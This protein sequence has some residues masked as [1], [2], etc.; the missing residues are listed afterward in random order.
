MKCIRENVSCLPGW[1]LDFVLR[2]PLL[3]LV[4]AMLATAGLLRFT[5]ANFQVNT[6]LSEMISPD[7][8][9]RKAERA[10]QKAFP[11]LRDQ[12]AL[13]VEAPTPEI[14]RYGQ[15]VLA[16]RLAATKGL[17]RSIYTPGGGDF[18]ARNGLLYLPVADLQGL[19]DNL[20]EMQ[21][22]LGMLPAKLTPESF[23]SMLG[24]LIDKGG[25]QVLANR[26][27]LSLFSTLASAMD[28][29]AAGRLQEVSWEGV[30]LGQKTGRGPAREFITLQ[31]VLD[32]TSLYPAHKAIDAIQQL[33]AG[34]ESE[35]GLAGVRVRLTGDL[36]LQQA[37]MESVENGTVLAAV[38][39]M[40][41]VTLLL[42]MG[43][44]SGLLTAASLLT[45]ALGLIWTMGFAIGAIGSL[46]LISVTFVVLFIG[47]GVDFSIQICLRYRE[48]L[49]EGKERTEAVRQAAAE[50]FNPQLVSAITIAI[51]FYA[52]V[53][54]AYAGASELGIISGTGIVLFLLANHAVL[55]AL[56]CLLPVRKPAATRGHGIPFDNL[57]RR[58]GRKILLVAGLLA[59]ASLF[60][61][62]RVRFDYN[63]LDLS[64]P[65]AEAVEVAKEL[66]T[67]GQTSPWT[68]SIIRKGLG[69][70]EET[71]SRLSR[72]PEVDMA[73]TIASYVPEQQKEK[74]AIIQDTA[75]FMPPLPGPPDLRS[76]E[77]EPGYRGLAALNRALARQEQA[78][79]RPLPPEARALAA[80][81]DRLGKLQGSRRAEAMDLLDRGL[82]F[83]LGLALSHLQGL[84]QPQPVTLADLPPELKAQYVSP[85]GFYRIEVFPRQNLTR[86][87]NL[88]NFVH[89]IRTV[90]PDATDSPVAILETGNAIFSSFER[91]AAY[92]LGLITVL[93][94]LLLW[95]PAE[96]ALTLLPLLLAIL[97]TMAASV[98]F[99]V[100]F[101]YANVIAIPLLI[102]G[103]VEY[104]ILLIFRF[105]SARPGDRHLLETSTARSVLFSAL[106]AMVGFASL[107]L[108][109]HRGTA[110]M[111]ILL[112][113]CT[114]LMIIC[115]LTILPAI[116]NY[117]RRGK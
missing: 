79:N 26:R 70:A 101:N 16:R 2:R 48:L 54:T 40:T 30:M 82:L 47:L 111:G 27:F 29:A 89:A 51:G 13:V 97:Y 28:N 49:A 105:R 18:F 36:A 95:S 45:L 6:D 50:L 107:A 90:A 38:I 108:S 69:P 34:M 31:P 75:L 60:L 21:P 68:S 19:S 12:L 114:S 14:A 33:A 43:L 5:M 94:L 109:S 3:V 83:N 1:W 86:I 39:S 81:G 71:A 113:V 104:G 66:F 63:P 78:A 11:N 4:V 87:R 23:F 15:D 65:K 91:A 84:L 77:V 62:P 25:D 88:E 42:I 100:P 80:A 73:L 102:G 24:G 7:L 8:P 61:L 98:L 52:F 55:P 44:H 46:N 56:L 37:D 17:F 22:F 106:A 67:T 99:S 96:T 117:Y 112:S 74:L 115:N 116:L 20:A 58:H 76:L 32:Y 85:Q 35:P 72:L 64:N 53:P 9:F 92:A 93:L 10:F 110:S 59:I 103:G 41:L 57:P